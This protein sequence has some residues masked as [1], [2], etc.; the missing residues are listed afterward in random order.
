M[1]T[2]VTVAAAA[3]GTNAVALAAADAT[4]QEPASVAAAAIAAATLAAT[5]AAATAAAAA[6]TAAAVSPA[7]AATRP[8]SPAEV[9][10][11]ATAS[12][13][14]V[15]SLPDRVP[16]SPR[17]KLIPYPGGLKA[18]HIFAGPGARPEPYASY[19]AP[20]VRPICADARR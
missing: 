12:S 20:R 11:K 16:G 8:S 17:E 2:I 13:R 7:T 15:V 19:V 3:V 5:A 1:A 10:S 9:T 4:A 14:Y 18:N 6:A